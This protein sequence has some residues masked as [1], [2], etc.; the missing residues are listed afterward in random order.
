MEK[1]TYDM[2]G[3]QSRIARLWSFYKES[4]IHM[5]FYRILIPVAII[6][7]IIFTI[8]YFYPSQLVA[9]L[10]KIMFLLVWVLF[11]PQVFETS[12]GISIIA[13]NGFVHGRLN[14]MYLEA[15]AKYE[16]HSFGLLYE[17]LPYLAIIVW[18]AGLVAISALWFI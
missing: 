7:A 9:L 15:A 3:G 18:T 11:I 14:K 16:R 6:T 10:S 1:E 12:K 2:R 17:A 13:T 4:Y 8:Q 5:L